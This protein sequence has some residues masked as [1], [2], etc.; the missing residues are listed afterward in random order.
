MSLNKSS[1][2]L[3]SIE[4]D[5]YRMVHVAPLSHVSGGVC[6][7]EVLHPDPCYFLHRLRRVEET[8]G[9]DLLTGLPKVLREESV[10][11]GVDA[12]VTVGQAVRHDAERERGVVQRE[13]SKFH[14]HGYDMVGHPAEE[15]RCDNQQHGLRRLTERKTHRVNFL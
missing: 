14:P 4:R 3:A 13:F 6:G 10:E 7:G 12:G 1:S 9:E 8:A 15:E 11:N 5:S 2:D